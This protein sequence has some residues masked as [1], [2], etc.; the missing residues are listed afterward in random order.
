MPHLEAA[1]HVL[2]L[3]AVVIG[4]G[5]ALAWPMRRLGQPAVMAEVLA[6]VLLGP[7]ILGALVP[8]ANE[9][10]LPAPAAL[11]M[12]LLAD[13]GVVLYLFQVGLEVDGTALRAQARSL[14]MIAAG[15]LVMPFVLGLAV[16]P[17]L[18]PQL[19]GSRAQA[20]LFFLFVAVAMSV[21]A[22]PVLARLLSDQGL[23]RTRLGQVALGAAAL[24]DVAAWGL[25]AIVAALAQRE[26]GRAWL[27]PGLFV[28]FLAGMG[29]LGRP[30]LARLSRRTE[31]P[32]VVA[33]LVLAGLG[34]WATDR[35]GV[36][37]A[38]GAFV[39]GLLVPHDSPLARRINDRIPGFVSRALMPAFFA[40]SGLRTHLGLI[41]DWQGWLGCLGLVVVAV[42][43]KVGGTRLM[44]SR[45]KLDAR[46]GLALGLLLNTRG[47]VEL[48]VLNVGL[49]LGLLSP[50]LFAMLVVMA[51]ATTFSTVPLLRRFTPE[52]LHP[53][54]G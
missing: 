35:I 42:V 52:F 41:D 13:A 11:P 36:H 19:A 17:L 3:L 15:S 46:E 38:F 2:L 24:A 6:G 50:R 51:L 25:L 18:W 33:L 45:A 12:E 22:F 14:G 7:S 49:D 39:V 8:G 53:G 9:W 20:P 23:T 10:L 30:L 26:P 34:A 31:R 48:V 32:A 37:A 29:I 54:A 1:L 47:L 16:A 43:G 5:R 28:L 44:A 4:L 40:W 21:T 27:T